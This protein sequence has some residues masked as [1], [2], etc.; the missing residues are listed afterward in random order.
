MGLIEN[1]IE[2][3]KTAKKLRPPGFF[4]IKPGFNNSKRRLALSANEQETMIYLSDCLV[5]NPQKQL[6][7]WI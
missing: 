5:G 2:Q 4:I 7:S 3:H 6:V 1:E